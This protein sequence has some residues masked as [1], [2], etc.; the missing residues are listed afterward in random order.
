[1]IWCNIC[2][3]AISQN[4]AHLHYRDSYGNIFWPYDKAKYSL[5]RRLLTPEISLIS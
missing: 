1:M 3:S 4:I 2:E 5:S